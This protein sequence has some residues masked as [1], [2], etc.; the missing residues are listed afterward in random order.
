MLGRRRV[1]VSFD[2]TGVFIC[3]LGEGYGFFLLSLAPV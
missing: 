3:C 2:L 1:E